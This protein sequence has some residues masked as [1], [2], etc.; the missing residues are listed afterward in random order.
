MRFGVWAPRASHVDLVIGDRRV[1]MPHIAD[2]SFGLDLDVPEGT[3]YAYSLD[4]GAPLPDPGSRHQPDG[5]HGASAVVEPGWDGWTDGAWRGQ[6][7]ANA[8][9]Y[10]LHVGTFTPEGTLDAAAA[11]LPDV[12]ALGATCVELMPVQ[13]FAGE[14]NW[15]YD[16]VS[17][18]AVHDAYG[19]P[20][21]LQ[22]FVDAAHA[23]GLAVCLDVVYN[24][25][26]PEGNYLAEYGPYFTDRYRTPW[27]GAVNFDGPDAIAS[28]TAAPPRIGSFRATRSNATAQCDSATSVGMF[29]KARSKSSRTG[30]IQ[31]RWARA[32]TS[33]TIPPVSLIDSIVV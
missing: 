32:A 20:A 3:R 11:R 13:P 28:S 15:G 9:L 7:L 1:A 30:R 24:H 6:D 26:G 19:G 4:G 14:R 23:H 17:L 5:V 16:G 10:E 25:L 12:A 2:G 27:G 18:H 8:V 21:A 33:G 22:R 31:R 29:L